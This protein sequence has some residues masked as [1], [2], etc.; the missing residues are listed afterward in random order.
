MDSDIPVDKWTPGTEVGTAAEIVAA[1]AAAA[2][3]AAGGGAL[4]R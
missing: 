3:V 2:A 4:C 1:A